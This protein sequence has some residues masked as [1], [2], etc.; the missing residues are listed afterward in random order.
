MALPR[1]GQAVFEHVLRA[2]PFDAGVDQAAATAAWVEPYRPELANALD[3]GWRGSQ[4]IG[5]IFLRMP[6]AN[7]RELGAECWDHQ[8]CIASGYQY[9]RVVGPSHLRRM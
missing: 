9:T 8:L 1:S 3:D 7:L 2:V 5:R 6:A 4:M